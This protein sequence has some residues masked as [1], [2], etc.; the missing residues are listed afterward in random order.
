M[1]QRSLA[2]V[3]VEPA[4]AMTLVAIHAAGDTTGEREKKNGKNKSTHGDFR[5][6][7]IARPGSF[8]QSARDEAGFARIV[9]H[10]SINGG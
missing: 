2:F 4:P 10:A 7:K 9:T 3:R 8:S 1:K 5:F 6:W